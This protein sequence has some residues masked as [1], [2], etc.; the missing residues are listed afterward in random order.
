MKNWSHNGVPDSPKAWLRKV[1][2]NQLIDHHRRVK[3]YQE[4]VAPKLNKTSAETSPQEITNDIIEDS[5]LQMIFVVCDPEL[6]KEAQICLALRILCGFH[7]GEI[8]RALFSNEEAIKKKL[9]RAKKS[10]R[11]RRELNSELS[12]KDYIKRLDNVLRVIYLLFNEGYYSSIKEENI[13]EDICWEA[14]RLT[15]FLAKQK[16]FAKHKIHAL[17]ALICFHVSRLSARKSGENGD[18][19]YHE[20]DRSKWNRAL[21]RKGEQYLNLS[22][23]GDKISKYHLE[24]SIAYW[25][26][27]DKPSKWENILQL[28]NRLLS[29][30]YST[31]IAMNQTYA[32]AMANSVDEAL[33]QAMKLGI[34]N[35]HHYACLLA[36]LYRMKCNYEKE[37][38][39]LNQALLLAKKV[40]EKEM[41]KSKLEIAHAN[42]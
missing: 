27:V 13:R 21:I 26:T 5:Q 4:K 17:L 36:E 16:H 40:N 7:T 42:Q 28:Y 18:L 9:Y 31:T 37:I 39:Y 8:A 12:K 32:L 15:I 35:N 33:T 29:L 30:E 19:L 24:A 1:A 10:I 38:E 22:A 2:Q 25:H 20:Q 34:E 41:I 3:T 23:K 6:N 11:E 14:M